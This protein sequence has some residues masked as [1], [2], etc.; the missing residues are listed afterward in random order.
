M[1]NPRAFFIFIPVLL[2]ALVSAVFAE[3]MPF[4]TERAAT[5][6]IIPIEGD[7]EPAMVT[8]V[9][10]EARRALDEGAQYLIFEVDTFGGRVDS[11]L[12]ITSFIMS[13]KKAK[14]IAWVRNSES[15]MGVSWSAGALIALSCSQIY[16]ANGTSMGAAAPVTIGS[17]GKT[18]GTGEKT[19]A[20][21]RSQIAALAEKNG[22]PKG[23]ALAMVDYDVELWEVEADGEIKVLTLQDLERM[24]SLRPGQKDAPRTLRRVGIISP[25]GKLLSLTAGEAYHF[26]LTRGLAD[27]RVELLDHLEAVML[28]ESFPSTWDSV[29]SFMVS[30]PV[31]GVLILIGL[32]L[33]F[34][35]LQNPGF[36]I[37]GTIGI[38][39]FVL[40]FGSS[41]MLGRVGSLEII[42]FI[43]GLG[44]LAVEVFLIPGFGAV[45]ISGIILIGLSL[46]FSMQ[47][48]VIPQFDWEWTLMGRNAIVVCGGLLAAITGI[49]ILALMGPKLKMFNRLTLKTQIDQTASEGGGWHKDGTVEFDY[50]KLIGK[51][52]KA[53][54]VLRPIGKAEID[55]D[56]FQ[57]ETGGSFINVGAEIKVARVQGNT[58]IVRSV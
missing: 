13:I 11:A 35:E 5:A 54:T 27:D 10:R 53:V 12:Q 23:I 14:T 7:I 20:A 41:F 48:F 34:M 31:Q 43:L 29:I 18:E 2:L 40:V 49:A 42:L 30:G 28:E 56:T 15:S 50:S 22:H 37:P 8:F 26:G 16:M 25:K 19:V 44:L 4:G 52:G 55:G 32:I 58:I 57:V 9:R 46:I 6:W 47:D 45:G 51:T 38:I 33:L 39:S 21:V 24:E 17:D 3:E 1:K 36:G